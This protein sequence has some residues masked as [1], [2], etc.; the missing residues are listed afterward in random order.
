MNSVPMSYS[1]IGVGGA[2]GAMLRFGLGQAATS[3]MG[4]TYPWG[5]LGVNILGGFLMGVLAGWATLD[6]TGS[7]RMFFGVGVLGG[8]TTF[9][10]FSLE[11]AHMLER[12]A[13][14]IAAGYALSS[15]MGSVLALLI[16]LFIARGLSA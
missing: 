11:M 1:L 13:W 15:V 9:S 7:A 6:H 16:G 14:A 12:A 3:L 5:T 8:F 2:I 10:A 4:A